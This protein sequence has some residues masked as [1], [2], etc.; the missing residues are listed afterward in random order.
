MDW[1]Q[2]GLDARLDPRHLLAG[3]RSL[4][5]VGMNYFQPPPPQRGRIATYALGHDYHDLIR[6]RLKQVAQWM[7]SFG[8][9]QRVCVDTSPL[10]EKV[11]A[12]QAGLG[13]QG[14]NTLLL[15][16]R[17]GTWLFLGSILTTLDLPPDTPEKD[18]CGSCTRCLRACPTAAI[19]APYQLDARRCLAYLSIEHRGP[20]PLEFRRAMGDRVYGCDDCLTVCPWNRWA[21]TTREVSFQPW[22]RPD[23]RQ[24]LAWDDPT[25]RAHFRGHPIFRLKRN[26]WLRNIAVVLGNIGTLEDLPALEHAS[27]DPDPLISEHAQWA[28]SEI[29]AR[30]N[31]P[32]DLPT[33]RRE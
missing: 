4:I 24:M 2:K 9:Q 17:H 31:P 22:P 33:S 12:A 15:H 26:R 29:Q 3:A 30:A 28:V 18:H 6:E 27:H 23:L 5:V 10:L 32:S 7:E 20:I 21:Q 8:S 16:R 14:K 11:A 1:M 13:W 19:T 25:F